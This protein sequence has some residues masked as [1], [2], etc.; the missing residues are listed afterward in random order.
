[1]P[2]LSAVEHFT[3]EGFVKGEKACR[4]VGPEVRDA[5]QAINTAGFNGVPIDE[6][7]NIAG[8]TVRLE[9]IADDPRRIAAKTGLSGWLDSREHRELCLLDKGCRQTERRD[10]ELRTGTWIGMVRVAHVSV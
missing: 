7:R 9:F 8:P 1:M 6:P 5:I 10:I 4:R 3:R 2:S